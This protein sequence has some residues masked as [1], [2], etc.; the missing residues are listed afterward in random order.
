MLHGLTGTCP[1]EVFG[2]RTNT[3][4]KRQDRSRQREKPT[5][6]PGVGDALSKLPFLCCTVDNAQSEK[7]LCHPASPMRQKSTLLNYCADE[8][9]PGTLRK[10]PLVLEGGRRLGQVTLKNAM[11]HPKKDLY[12]SEPSV[13]E[14]DASSPQKRRAPQLAI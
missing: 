14:T 13:I 2:D 6:G 3:I 1:S 4:K 11:P 8:E 5:C 7:S 9:S 12:P 10:K